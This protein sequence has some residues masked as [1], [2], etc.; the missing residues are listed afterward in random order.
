MRREPERTCIVTRRAGTPDDLI[1][2]VV[3]PDGTIVP[4]IAHRL[5]GRGLWVTATREMVAKAVKTKAFAK[6]AKAHVLVPHDLADQVERLIARRVLEALSLANKA[7]A[8]VTGFSRVE[9]L[10]GAGDA[11][12]VLHSADAAE[13]GVGKLDRLHQAVCREAGK[14]AVIHRLQTS[15]EMSLALGRS[16][17]VHVALAPGGAT[18]FFFAE[19]RRLDIYTGKIPPSDAPKAAAAAL[20]RKVDTGRE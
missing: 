9:A 2:F 14:P 19:L 15:H 16:N 20:P 12:A 3:A 1:R 11:A 5:P 6:A 4:D 10:I 7:G 18:R 13:D 8:V 17:V